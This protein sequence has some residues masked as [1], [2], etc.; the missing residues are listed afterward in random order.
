MLKGA[1]VKVDLLPSN[2]KNQR[3]DSLE[4]RSIPLPEEENSTHSIYSIAQH[5]YM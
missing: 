3:D 4:E 2:H 1:K 5:I